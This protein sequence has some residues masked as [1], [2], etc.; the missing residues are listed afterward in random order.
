MCVYAGKSSELSQAV[1]IVSRGLVKE[2]DGDSTRA[3]EAVEILEACSGNSACWTA[4]VSKALP[5]LIE[6]LMTETSN[7]AGT[8]V[9][10]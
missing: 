9:L 6:L 3:L 2:Q 5:A 8:S 4:I 10:A 1:E 7:E